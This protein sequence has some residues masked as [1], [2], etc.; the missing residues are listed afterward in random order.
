MQDQI[1]TLKSRGLRAEAITKKKEMS[2][3][4]IYDIKKGNVQ[5]VFC[6]PEALVQS[7]WFNVIRDVWK[8]SLC[9][10]C[11]DEAHCVSEWG[12]SFRPEYR[13]VAMI[14]SIADVPVLALTAT[15]TTKVKSDIEKYLYI[16]E[17]CNVIAAI[18]DRYI[19]SIQTKKL[20]I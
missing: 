2:E 5:F 15:V 8:N 13:Q 12:E 9:M 11:F 6:S 19:R 3:N 4:V 1:D 16:K 17:D 14:R 10:I 20:H 7:E 18:P